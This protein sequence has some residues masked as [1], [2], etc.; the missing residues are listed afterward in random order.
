MVNVNAQEYIDKK[1]PIN[2]VCERDSD[3]ENKNKT[4]KGITLLDLRKGKV[5]NGVFK[6]NKN[7]T[8]SL[9]LDEFNNLRRLIISSHQLISLDVSNC[10]NLEELDCH[11]NEL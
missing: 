11:G 1:Y 2:G 3:P 7:L 4:R 8:E 9:K 5:G 10:P 6:N